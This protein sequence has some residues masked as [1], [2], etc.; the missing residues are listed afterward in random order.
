MSVPSNVLT[1][2]FLLTSVPRIVGDASVPLFPP[3]KR[4]MTCRH[5]RIEQ[6]PWTSF[7]ALL[8]MLRVPR[9]NTMI[10]Q[11]K[12][13]SSPLVP[14]SFRQCLKVRCMTSIFSKK[15]TCPLHVSAMT[16]HN[17]ISHMDRL[18]RNVLD[19]LNRV[20]PHPYFHGR[21]HF[22]TIRFWPSWFD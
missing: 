7:R 2:R 20:I 3:S 10:F 16:L 18:L 17:D 15:M 22:W 11:K 5:V 12:W 19:V 8:K 13:S 21:D 9:M 6:S 14:L 4:E 1:D